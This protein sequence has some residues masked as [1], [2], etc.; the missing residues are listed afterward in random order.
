MVERPVFKE[1]MNRLL[2][3]ASAFND[4]SFA[5]STLLH[6]LATRLQASSHTTFSS[7]MTFR[8]C[9]FSSQGM[10]SLSSFLVDRIS[11]SLLDFMHVHSSI[12]S[13]SIIRSIFFDNQT[14]CLSFT[15]RTPAGC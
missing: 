14:G 11:F 13:V 15:S 2:A 12:N 8:T 5:R 4:T 10:G 9:L 3:S 6:I 1:V 7:T